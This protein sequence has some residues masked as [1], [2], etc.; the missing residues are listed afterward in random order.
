MPPKKAKPS[1]KAEPLTKPP[2]VPAG[3]KGKYATQFWKRI[4]KELVAIQA[5]TELHLESL[6]LLCRIWQDFRELSD[7]AESHTGDHIVTYESGHI[8]E[9][10]KLRL[11]QT[12][13]SNLHRLLPK[14]GL[15]PEGLGK[16]SRSNPAAK[17]EPIKNPLADFAAEKYS[18]D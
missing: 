3:L 9:H 17:S 13:F 14:F 2:K 7:W 4:T 10:P 11:R 5:I 18:D 6:E 16:I 15:T 1:P 12:A 8:V